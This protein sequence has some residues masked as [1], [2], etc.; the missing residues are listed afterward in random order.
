MENFVL[1]DSEANVGEEDVNVAL[2]ALL[3]EL[4]GDSTDVFGVPKESTP[5][6]GTNDEDTEEAGA[7]PVA[8]ELD[9]QEVVLDEQEEELEDDSFKDVES[10]ELVAPPEPAEDVGEFSDLTAEDMEILGSAQEEDELI[11][12][13]DLDFDE[14]AGEPEI[15]LLDEPA[16]EPEIEPMDEP[17]GEPEVEL[18]DEPVEESEFELADGSADELEIEPVDESALDLDIDLVE[19][20][21]SEL[22][23][24]PVE[25]PAAEPEPIDEPK[26]E[27]VPE[28]VER[29]AE[30]QSEPVDESAPEPATEPGDVEE[31]VLDEGPS[32]NP[33]YWAEKDESGDSASQPDQAAA[34][35]ASAMSSVELEQ[36]DLG[37]QTGASR[38]RWIPVATIVATLALIVQVFW[39]QRD[40]WSKDL[41]LRPIYEFGCSVFSCELA[42]L[43]AVDAIYSKNLVVRQHPEVE[44]ALIVDALV[45]NGAHFEQPY[46]VVELRFSAMG[47]R[48]VAGRRFQPEEYLAGEASG[49]KMMASN[50]P[51]HISLS[52]KDPGAE[53]VNYVML[54]H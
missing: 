43:R 25:E 13:D 38:R 33:F 17:T 51:V 41:S 40:D 2:D 27:A 23:I 14:P 1:E 52:I 20:P 21:A 31:I 35:P 49:A 12:L 37:G 45:I 3:S 32:P 28:P 34:E 7:A 15:E 10:I 48:T 30:A 5:I 6:K 53:A 4:T 39:S 44:D 24:E 16:G 42:P 36:A 19:E 22:G 50:T 11:N 18:V 9:E 26:A 46:P 54:F 47:G 29:K 8:D